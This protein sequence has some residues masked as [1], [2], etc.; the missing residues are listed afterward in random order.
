M[1]LYLERSGYSEETFHT[2][3]YSP[4]ADDDG[5]TVGMLCV[6]TEVTERVIGERQLA[7]LRDLGV[8]L[9][10]AAT[11][12]EVMAALETC[13]EAEPRDLPFAL[14]YL[15]DDGRRVARRAALHGLSPLSPGAAL[16]IDLAAERQ[17]WP[18]GRVLRHRETEIV[19]APV[20]LT[21]TVEQDFW[22]TPP[23]RAMLVP[24]HDVEGGAPMGFIV[25]GLN[26]HRAVT[27]DY[28]GF[29]EL[30]TGQIGAAV[31]RADTFERERARAEA[32]AAL[33]LAKT[34]FFSNISHEFRTP[35]TLMLGPLEEM[36][37]KPD[38]QRRPDQRRLVEMAHRNSL[39]LLR[40]VNA[41]LDF[42]RIEAGRVQG[43]FAPTDLAAVTAD[44]ASTFRSLC[45][46][47][48]LTLTIACEPLPEP[49]YVDREMWEKV[50]LNL[51]SNAFKFT[52]EGGIAVSLAAAGG[53]ARLCVRDS[54]VGIPQTELPN[55]FERF[56]RVEGTRGRSFEGSGIGLALVHDLMALHGG[57]IAVESAEGAGA[58]FTVE[59]PFGLEHL[60]PAQIA[61][62]TDP[63]PDS[64]RAAGYL[65]EASRWLSLEPVLELLPDTGA[66]V[67]DEGPANRGRILVADDN[68]DLRDYVERLLRAKGYEVSVAI[69]G[70]AALEALE[71]GRPDLLITDVMMPR[72]DGFGLLARVRQSERL[73][74]LP[75]IMLSARSGEES[76]VEG[77]EAGAD[78]YLTKP[79]SARELIARVGANLA[80][81]DI[82]GRVAAALVESEARFRSM[83]D[84]APVMLW[85]TDRVGAGIYLNQAWR[86]FT[87]HGDGFDRLAAAH[88]SDRGGVKRALRQAHAA[89]VPFQIDYRLRRADGVYRWV[90]ETAAPRF[91]GAGDFIGCIG[92]VVDISDRKQA[93]QVLEQ[94]VEEAVGD[95]MKAEEALRQAQKMEAVG[96]LTGG[97]AHDFNNLLQGIAGSLD[98]I[99]RKPDDVERV[100]RWSEAGLMAAERG[101]RLTGQLLAFSRTQKLELRPL[102]LKGVVEGFRPMLER[103]IGPEVQIRLD[104]KDGNALVLA[105]EVQLEMAILNLALNARD[106]MPNGGALTIA[107]RPKALAGDLE[108]A[109]GDY[110]ELIV[111]DTGVGIAAD[112]LGRVF[113]PFFTTKEVGKG[114]GL[115][116]SQVYGAVR[117]AGGAVRIDSQP[118][119][120]AR[121]SL[122]LRRAFPLGDAGPEAPPEP[123]PQAASATV[124]VIDDDAGVRDFLIGS[125]EALGF[126][127]VL[128]ESGLRAL[129]LLD[130]ANP[131]VILL[132]YAMPGLN[133]AQIAND[134]RG[135]RPGIPIV[136]ATGYAETAAIEAINGAG[137]PIL[138]KPFSVDQLEIALSRALASAP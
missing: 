80:M 79:F 14:A 137:G 13:L 15:C 29:I 100:R 20:A 130:A 40:L 115:G 81:A 19:D 12:Q 16:E 123:P 136:F 52:F 10:G 77:L 78:D 98:L 41:L 43:R 103:T 118:G 122:I 106:A 97:I 53:R 76:K 116:L 108:L 138:R 128:A 109:D 45:D 31:V 126:R 69:D 27:P 119:E 107:T 6:V 88:P 36:L 57:S 38:S 33:D 17:P 113:D 133:G 104:L 96:Q 74:D 93:E 7:S 63:H 70:Q 44:L 71:G 51:L 117:Q 54:G 56:H 4:L 61:G 67:S 65:E 84:H 50:V 62:D 5:A 59:I 21:G 23:S 134:I 26:P 132:D 75:V 95:R 73:R 102:G 32:L 101:A 37:A 42:S 105:D 25:A 55:L 120:G 111:S 91:D 34:Q 110:V 68:A 18:L 87:G 2:F 35:L 22:Q 66:S 72:L 64:A 99:R 46:R 94:R 9:A 121:I 86:A 30:L 3:S 114:T 129:E 83:A 24:I 39:R 48:G 92:S 1:Q 112:I 60:P 47:A 85:V 82:R 135:R 127:A 8:R 28:R 124:L 125:L 49:V 89:H 131:D 11:R 90:V 58:A